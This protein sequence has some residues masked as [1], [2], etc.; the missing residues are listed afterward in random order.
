MKAKRL[1]I[2]SVAL[3]CAALV[4]RSGEEPVDLNAVHRLRTEAFE[5]SH[6]MEH[7]FYLTDVYGPRLTNSPGFRKAGDW[8]VKRLAEYG[9]ANTKLE[10]WGPFGRGWS[11]SGFEAE[12]IEPGYQTLIGFP[13][14]WAPGTNGTLEGEPI[15]APMR[16]EEDLAR[17]K[18]KLKGKIVLI[19]LPRE[20]PVVRYEPGVRLTEADL[21]RRSMFEIP[22]ANAE[23]T[24]PSAP[25]AARGPAGE[26]KPIGPQTPKDDDPRAESRRRDRFRGKMNEFLK[27]EGALVAVSTGYRGDGGTV[28][29]SSAGSYNS[30]YPDPPPSIAIT[31]E[32]YNRIVRLLEKK[33]GVKLRIAVKAEFHT[34]T[35]DSFNVVGEIPGGSK[36]DEVVMVGAHFDSWHGGTGATDNAAGSAVMMEVVR[37]LKSLGRP[38][39]RTVRIA[40]W[41]GEEVGLLGSKAYVKEHFADPEVMRTTSA[42]AKLAAYFNYDNGTG[43]IRGVYLQGND[44]CR[45]IFEAWLRPYH[46]LGATTVTIRNTRGT[47]HLSFDA[48]GLPGFQFVQDPVEYETRTHHSNMDTYDHVQEA[49]LKQAAAI[50]AGFA[51]HAAMREQ[52]LPR[53]PLPKPSPPRKEDAPTGGTN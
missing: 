12:M 24:S 18:G 45:P 10:K 51:Y 40:L 7:L 2:L 52:M 49:D 50:I 34:E 1:G 36:K 5:R 29:A 32:H 16:A 53:K 30:K 19:D 3:L 39:D 25:A 8:A 46:D 21:R 42:H 31:P 13:L 22:G 9:L 38:L 43:R 23:T 27:Q 20:T 28:F 37:V 26:P 33:I 11:Y 15:L 48:V 47:D 44:M 6:V 14:A 4:A 17:Y 35:P 41:G